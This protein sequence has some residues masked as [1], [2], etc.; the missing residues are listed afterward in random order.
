M[1]GTELAQRIR[2]R[3]PRAVGP[4]VTR[5]VVALVVSCLVA[6]VLYWV[7]L[8]HDKPDI[9]NKA[10]LDF[11]QIKQN[12]APPAVFDTGQPAI[13]S[14]NPTDPGSN[15]FVADGK[16][17]YSPTKDGI[18]AAAYGTSDMGAPVSGIGARFVF[19]P[20][21]EARTGAIGLYVSQKNLAT[22]PSV[23][24]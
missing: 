12:G 3:D 8:R 9:S 19:E 2:E 16:L 13:I 18:A 15:F 20:K 7:F 22:L 23:V 10:E 6:G 17:T 5:I 21:S 14:N 4:L 24:P 1:I 11:S